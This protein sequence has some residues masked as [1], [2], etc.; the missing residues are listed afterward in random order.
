[1]TIIKCK[2]CGGDVALSPDKR[3][4]IC[5]YCGSSM[6]V[7]GADSEQRVSAFN[8]G[9]HFRR[10]GEFD[11]ALAIY[12]KIVSENEQDAEAHWCC[13]LC[14][15]GIEYVEDPNTL[16]WFPTC[17]RVS[18]DSFLEDVDYK[19]AVGYSDGITR[20]QYV[21][22]GLKIAEV[23]K[24]ILLTSQNAQAYD[25]FLCYKESD[26]NG[27]RTRDSLLAQE[28]YYQLTE[29]GRRVFY[30]RI[31]LEDVPGTQYEPYIFAALN[32]AKVM[33]VVGTKPEHLN[34]PWVKNE[35]SRFLTLMKKDS[36]RLLLP[37]YRDMD[38]Y[39]LPEQLGVLQSYDMSR[40]GFLPDLTRGISKV[41]DSKP[42][43][44]EAVILQ[45]T[46]ADVDPLLR[47]AFLFLEDGDWKTADEY[48]EKVLDRIPENA[49]AYLGKLLAECR[50]RNK[51]Q[52]GQS[53]GA[54]LNSAN[55]QK[56]L[57]FG[58]SSV[59]ELLESAGK[60]VTYYAVK[61]R[62]SDA[63]SEN[64]N[65]EFWREI[66]SALNTIP[67]W[68][69][70]DTLVQVCRERICSIEA[71]EE[72][73]RQEKRRQEEQRQKEAQRKAKKVKKTL[74]LVISAVCVALAVVLLVNSVVIPL[75]QNRQTTIETKKKDAK[76][77]FTSVETG[78]ADPREAAYLQAEA[79][80]ADGQLGK[81]AI[82]FGKLGDYSDA[83]QRSFSLWQ[84]V[85]PAPIG[86]ST[87]IYTAAV[88]KD[89]TVMLFDY[90][91]A[92]QRQCLEWTDIIAVSSNGASSGGHTV[93]LKKDGTVVAVGANQCNQCDTSSWS[94]V[95][96]IDT[97]EHG[98]TVGL[99][100][101]GT[102]LYTGSSLHGHETQIEELSSWQD[103]VV[104][105]LYYHR[106]IGIKSDGTVV[107]ARICEDGFDEAFKDWDDII[108]IDQGS[109]PYKGNCYF[110][111]KADGTV[112]CT[113]DDYQREVSQWTDIVAISG[114]FDYAIGLKSDGTVVSFGKPYHGDPLELS[115]WNDMAAICAYQT[116]TI[117]AKNDGSLVIAGKE[118]YLPPALIKN[119][120][121]IK[122]PN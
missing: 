44:K 78:P 76:S 36:S 16:E 117:G 49:E 12:E 1:M 29:Q 80:E 55:Y 109:I 121:D 95:I 22:E 61:Q 23:Q 86:Y 27:S 10:I 112:V 89:G 108:A 74:R 54:F 3:M 20:R 77:P 46:A 14:R 88:G 96:A 98:F 60:D 45:Q 31:T 24:G 84:Q 64:Q 105:R 9:N 18:F 15:F 106:V 34:S 48:C 63:S 42:L 81:A 104:I 65:K 13:A 110:G 40:I 28:I 118:K 85:M 32:S 82:A 35:W 62:I 47:R 119:W 6:T 7:P 83:R 8:R 99:K 101:D 66:M 115:E 73:Q 38:P 33:I 102:V 113:Y 93:G 25:I 103:I 120:S 4:G 94:D 21:K 70:A 11:K 17:H 116:G 97:T 71:E 19:A 69:D 52:L 114:G 37:C 91:D 72:A 57:R 87:D 53:G 100:S 43:Q 59:K 90:T 41:L 2:M 5:E 107:T 75:L 122:L 79:L 68:Q 92:R 58:D 26:E 56:A 111:V 67:G 50:I 30:S 39:D 51:E